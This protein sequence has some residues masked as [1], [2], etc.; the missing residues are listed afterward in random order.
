MREII[1]TKR[2]SEYFT[3]EGLRTLTGLTE[4]MWHY[5]IFKELLDNALDA[6][7]TVIEKSV[8][9]NVS[10]EALDILDSGGGIPEAI[11]DSIH[12][13]SIYASD[14]REFRTPTRGYQGNALKTVIAI[15]YLKGYDLEYLHSGRAYTYTLDKLKL[16][17]GIIEFH[18]NIQTVDV[19]EGYG[20]VRITGAGYDLNK[21]ESW[22]NEYRSCNPDVEFTLND[23]VFPAL[24]EAQERAGKTYI[25]WYDF[26]KFNQLMQAI[27]HK[28]PERT[29]K[30][31][32][33]TFSSTQRIVSKLEIDQ[34]VLSEMSNDE[35]AV[36]NM[37]T[38]LQNLTK[39]A[40]PSMLEKHKSGKDAL[41]TLFADDDPDSEYK[42]K[43]ITGEYEYG[44]AKIPYLLEG[45]LFQGKNEHSNMKAFAA[46]NNSIPYE[47]LPFYCS[48]DERDFCKRG[49]GFNSIQGLLDQA[50]INEADGLVLFINYVSPFIEF[51]DKAK[52]RI[53]ADSFLDDLLKLLTALCR[54]TIKEV[55][56]ARRARRGF[57]RKAAVVPQQRTSKKDLMHQYFY[58]GYL[59]A[60]GDEEY[61]TKARQVFYA[62]RDMINWDHEVDL[63]QSDYNTFSQ[64][65]LTEKFKSDSTLEEK[66]LLD[67]RGF[68]TD[69]FTGVEMPVGTKDVLDYIHDKPVNKIITSEAKIYSIPIHL[70]FNKVLFIEKEG[71]N[72]ILT[73][74]GLVDELGL[75]IISTKGFGTRAAKKLILHLIDNNVK[76]Y[77][78]NDC[79]IAG[80]LIHEKFASGSN[81]FEQAL[82]VEHLGLTVA[83]IDDLGKRDKAEV[84]TYRRPYNDA[85][86]MLT[87][88]EREFFI[89]DPYA[90]QK[91]KFRRV[92]INALTTPEIIAYLRERIPADPI[93]PT[94]GELERYIEVD[95]EDIVKEALY[96]VYLKHNLNINIDAGVIAERVLH[97]LGNGEGGRHWTSALSKVTNEVKAEEVK[98]LKN[99]VEMNI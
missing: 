1:E 65:V 72:D 76:V 74:S 43:L 55:E 56:K 66:I 95:R 40:K 30:Q 97:V 92:E 35:E 32:C 83:D 27:A 79:D 69:P 90:Y 59:M 2:D 77:L 52:T 48:Y 67:R 85:L 11:L 33:S 53:N 42:Y 7:D 4:N 8:V 98:R 9:V 39:P 24:I 80:Y 23:Q 84:A 58:R 93:M 96:Q 21:V 29:I 19:K 61:L 78:F 45:F 14:K 10:D 12:D 94:K 47:L 54:D 86:E 20:G 3:A 26:P 6:L 36:R 15:C 57:S 88:D 44:E 17:G 25:H 70:R 38:Q 99:W 28:D 37:F 82:P 87:E 41:F 34:Q 49:Y 89:A 91:R 81:T 68:F 51:T 71:F 16:Q 63:N 13:Y 46:V 62:C 73:R 18:K 75:G 60:S 5:A 22:L 31:F 64:E 50:G